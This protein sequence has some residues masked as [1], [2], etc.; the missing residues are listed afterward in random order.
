MIRT[1]LHLAEAP[2][3][4]SSAWG[5][6]IL[7]NVGAP[8]W[9]FS[10]LC[11]TLL[12]QHSPQRPTLPAGLGALG[13]SLPK[14]TMIRISLNLAKALFPESGAWGRHILPSVGAPDC[15][16][17]P[18]AHSLPDMFFE[19]RYRFNLPCDGC[20]RGA[21]PVFTHPGLPQI[22]Y[23]A[24][25]VSPVSRSAFISG[26]VKKQEAGHNAL[27]PVTAPMGLGLTA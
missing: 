7:P 6:H 26:R 19:P 24:P 4:E 12:S 21:A 16:F 27:S 13:G 10:T 3:P 9:H 1:A 2:S 22:P 5:R 11:P 25:T 8:D 14:S 18:S 15:R 20:P 17:S 23:G